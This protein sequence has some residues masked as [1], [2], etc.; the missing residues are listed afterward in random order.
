V[1]KTGA[2]IARAA[3]AGFFGG[4]G[5]ALKSSSQTN[6]LSPLGQVSQLDPNKLWQAGVGG[7]LSEGFKEIQKFYM[8]LSRQTLPTIEIL[9]SQP[10]TLVVTKGV[11]LDIR[12]LKK[13]ARV[14]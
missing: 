3:M 14:D 10:V 11:T 12:K 2:M 1:A 9:P 5:E 6:S 8:E 7:G 13:G 4:A